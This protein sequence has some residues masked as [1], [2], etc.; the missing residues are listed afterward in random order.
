MTHLEMFNNGQYLDVIADL[1]E[2][3]NP[4]DIW[5]VVDSYIQLK[6]VEEASIIIENNLSILLENDPKK[7]MLL[8]IDLYLMQEDYASALK[9]YDYFEKLPYISMEIEELLPTLKDYIFNKMSKHNK[10]L[11][12]EEIISNI[13]NPQNEE[14][15]IRMLY[16]IQKRD[17]KK[18]FL[19]LKSILINENVS[20]EVRTLALIL[21]VEKKETRE[22]K[23]I[24]NGKEYQVIPNDLKPIATKE[25]IM[26]KINAFIK[27]K[28]VSVLLAMQEFMA[29]FAFNIYP[30]NLFNGDEPILLTAFYY[31]TLDVFKRNFDDF[32]AFVAYN[33]LNKEEVLSRV[34]QIKEALSHIKI[35][36]K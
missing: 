27:E 34:T 28:D 35:D 17:L 22:V 23:I 31:F 26:Q 16:E 29:S 21:L 20:E 6:R 30:E 11:S 1:K 15:V 25:E 24:K 10:V 7:T 4:D 2:S 13:T 33:K 19:S 8:S 3:K 18:F 12:D 36:N 14:L 5:L 32:E 9:M